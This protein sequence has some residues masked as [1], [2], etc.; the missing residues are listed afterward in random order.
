LRPTPAP[1]IP[2]N[3]EGDDFFVRVDLSVANFGIEEGSLE[4]ERAAE[5]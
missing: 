2:R 3:N 5:K 1:H 4:E